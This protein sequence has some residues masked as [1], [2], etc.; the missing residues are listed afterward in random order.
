[1]EQRDPTGEAEAAETRRG[2]AHDRGEHDLRVGRLP[3]DDGLQRRAA[4]VHRGGAS[5]GSRDAERA[6]ARP[7]LPLQPPVRPNDRVA[8]RRRH[9]PRA[10]SAGNWYRRDPAN[11]RTALARAAQTEADVSPATFASSTSRKSRT[12]IGRASCRERVW[13]W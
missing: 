11:M 1:M 13:L 10:K 8:V 9:A 7:R 3:R 4:A 5:P 2:R 6:L 12:Q